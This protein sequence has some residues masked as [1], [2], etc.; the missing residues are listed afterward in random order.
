[1]GSLREGN[2]LTMLGPPCDRNEDSAVVFFPIKPSW[3]HFPVVNALSRYKIKRNGMGSK[4]TSNIHLRL[5]LPFKK[6]FSPLRNIF[7]MSSE[8][9]LV[10]SSSMLPVSCMSILD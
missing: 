3:C 8:I 9:V 4:R 1:M 7:F 6:H 2:A 10:V 5:L